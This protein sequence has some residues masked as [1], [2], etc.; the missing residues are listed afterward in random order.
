MKR[1]YL[2]DAKR[3]YKILKEG[4]IAI[5]Y[6]RNAYAIMSGTDSALQKVYTAKKRSLNRP[7]GLVANARTHEKLHILS[8]RKKNIIKKFSKKY[9]LPISIIAPYRK[10]HPIISKFSNF[11]KML[12]T[13]NNTVNLLLNSGPLR[14]NI[15][16]L[17]L[18]DNFPLI[19]SSANL[20][21]R[22]TKYRVVDIE[23]RVKKCADII[24]N[25]GPCELYKEGKTIDCDGLS[26]SS[27]QIDFRDMSIVRKGVY[28]KEIY[29]I[30]KDEFNINL[31]LRL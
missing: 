18:K 20:S 27:T 19:A 8:R 6:M 26:L 21:Q 28:F 22:G 14:E 23:D 2:K 17:S 9:N 5:V 15:A 4:G 25:Y 16:D 7:S 31:V 30:F 10:K 29:N 12:A 1:D 11:S 3:V 24:I 13:K